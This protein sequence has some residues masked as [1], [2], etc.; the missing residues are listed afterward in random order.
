MTLAKQPG[1]TAPAT[2]PSAGG[3]PT[4]ALLAGGC[5]AQLCTEAR[6]T[7]ASLHGKLCK[8]HRTESTSAKTAVP[9]SAS[10]FSW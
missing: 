3:L 6:G 10:F 5:R 4:P 7:A 8:T 9:S 2:A 1:M